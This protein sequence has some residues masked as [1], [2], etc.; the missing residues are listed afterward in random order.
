MENCAAVVRITVPWQ[1]S[2]LSRQPVNRSRLSI[3]VGK[4]RTLFLVLSLWVCYPLIKVSVTENIS[5]YWFVGG[6]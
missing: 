6:P 4:R 1:H 5:G 2:A 3:S